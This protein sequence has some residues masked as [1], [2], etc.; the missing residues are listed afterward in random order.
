MTECVKDYTKVLIKVNALTDEQM[1][2]PGIKTA[3]DSMVKDGNLEVCMRKCANNTPPI[4][5]YDPSSRV[6]MED[7]IK[8]INKSFGCKGIPSS[9]TNFPSSSFLELSTPAAHNA[10]G[11]L[12]IKCAFGV[13]NPIEKK[14][15]YAP[16]Y[17]IPG[18]GLGVNK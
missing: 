7:A 3:Y 14:C 8:I 12:T 1:K 17:Y 13:Y 5:A 15:D 10:K 2:N 18:I 16:A 11:S 6:S 4:S 9:E